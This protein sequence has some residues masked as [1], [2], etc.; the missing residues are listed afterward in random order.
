MYLGSMKMLN[1]R[2]LSKRC[3]EVMLSVA[4]ISAVGCSP[5]SEPDLQDGVAVAP[6]DQPAYVED[7]A[8]EACHTEQ[9]QD[10]AGS[11]HD[12][13]M[14]VASDGSVLGDFEDDSFTN[15]GVTTRFFTDAGR[16]MGFQWEKLGPV[17]HIFTPKMAPICKAAEGFSL[18]Q[19]TAL[20]MTVS[21]FVCWEELTVT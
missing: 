19:T 13:A 7:N 21:G 12:L 4:L 18:V 15:F 1:L 17:G 11:H 6:V 8:C 3:C 10:W 2:R 20:A 5:D 9:Y 16:F 14:Q